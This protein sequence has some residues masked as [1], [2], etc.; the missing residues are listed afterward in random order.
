MSDELFEKY[1]RRELTPEESLRLKE[2]LEDP[3]EAR[4]FVD[5]LQEWTALAEVSRR[6]ESL[7]PAARRRK[8]FAP[9]PAR[10][11]KVPWAAAGLA[12]A[13][14][15][16]VAAA[17]LASRSSPTPG[18]P[19]APVV[20]QASEEPPISDPAP[21]SRP[22]ESSVPPLPAPAG[23]PL[24]PPVAA[25][26]R[27]A[28]APEPPRPA[29][30]PLA[31]SESPP[32][33]PQL[34]PEPEP[35]PTLPVLAVLE[36]VRGE[37][38]LGAGGDARPGAPVLAGQALRVG[39]GASRAVVAFPDGTRLEVG[40]D[41]V[42][43][44]LGPGTVKLARGTLSASV[45]RR[46]PGAPL[47]FRTPHA[48][49]VVLGTELTL[50]AGPSSTRLEV[51][52]G[53]VRFRRLED[54]ATVDV[55]AGHYAVAE[56]GT[57][58][59]SRLL[60]LS[61]EFQD[62]LAG[63]AGTR[64]AAVSE[65]EPARSFGEAAEI[66]VDGDEAEGRKIWA[67]LRWDLSAISPGAVVQEAFLTLYVTRT[68]QGAG[69]ELYEVKRPWEEREV[70]WKQALGAAPWRAPGLRR[71][72]DRAAAPMGAVMPRET[73][74]TKILLDRAVVQAWVRNP[75]ANHGLVIATDRTSD[76][77][78]FLS[79]EARDPARRPKLTVVYTLGTR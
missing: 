28:P 27:P 64:D 23:A 12:A 26:E 70:T 9:P 2:L 78:R 5:F 29:A 3:A 32:A 73:G 41:T 33:R 77:F 18:T 7:L 57:R 69:Y 75:S 74:E 56:R 53:K 55:T 60:V 36:G 6:L 46:A 59:E 63:Y 72:L 51:R 21:L 79:R 43:D 30:P 45:A 19:E 16:A 24:R 13:A 66:E 47:T 61:L 76:G 40:S 35:P 62:G 10:A 39:G 14:L 4:R 34:A 71:G 17:L 8:A 1:L 50:S 65:V 52:E 58:L 11:P 25:P 38:V 48:E 37:V 20:R 42:M 67:L 31:A 54:S 44:H 15:G 68:S 22:Q 49:A